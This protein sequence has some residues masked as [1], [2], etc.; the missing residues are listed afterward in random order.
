MVLALMARGS[1]HPVRT[2]T[3]GFDDAR[4]R[5]AAHTRAAVARHFGDRPSPRR[6]SR[7]DAI[8]LLP[9]LADALRRAVRRLVG[10]PDLPRR[11]RWRRPHVRVVLTGDG[12][13][14]TFGGYGSYRSPAGAEPSGCP[15]VRVR[16]GHGSWPRLRTGVDP[17][18]RRREATRSRRS[19][20]SVALPRR[21][22]VRARLMSMSDLRLRA[23]LLRDDPVADQD[24]YLLSLMRSGP[25]EPARPDAR[26]GHR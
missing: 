9:D 10:D 15:A 23:R 18:G 12:G 3:I 26:R 16:R 19:K 25:R 14:E 17:G 13:D 22:A 4:L 20:S 11:R 8:G 7:L 5:R 24:G 1:E 2:F 6:S 21:R